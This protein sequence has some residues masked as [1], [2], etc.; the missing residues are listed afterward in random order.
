MEQEWE[1][2]EEEKT[3]IDCF[4]CRRCYFCLSFADKRAIGMRNIWER[5]ATNKSKSFP[6]AQK[7][8]RYGLSKYL[9]DISYST[10]F[11]LL[12][13][14]P[15]LSLTLPLTFFFGNRVAGRV[16]LV[17]LLHPFACHCHSIC[18]WMQFSP[19]SFPLSLSHYFIRCLFFRLLFA[20]SWCCSLP[21]FFIFTLSNFSDSNLQQSENC[22]NT[23]HRKKK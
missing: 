7:I 13:R 19:S 9:Y 15:H 5:E 4:Q 22:V 2:E 3:K 10:R 16:V 21:F 11:V 18:R 12:L 1:E 6:Y 8:L 14:S 20:S 17:H 23:R